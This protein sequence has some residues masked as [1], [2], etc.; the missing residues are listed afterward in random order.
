MIHEKIVPGEI[1]RY[2]VNDL[3]IHKKQTPG[4]QSD[5]T[6]IN[7]RLPQLVPVSLV[8]LFVHDTLEYY[9]PIAIRTITDTV[10]NT[11]KPVYNYTTLYSGTISSLE[12]K[13]F[14]FPTTPINNLEVLISDFDNESLTIDSVEVSGYIY[15]LIGRF[16]GE[17]KYIL[18]YGNG[19]LHT[20][21]YDIEKFSTHLSKELDVATLGSEQNYA[22]TTVEPS[23]SYFSKPWLWA[24][25]AIVILILG[26]FSLKMMNNKD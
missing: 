17:G 10:K 12:D 4:N 23:V 20:P 9:R 1:R 22:E 3:S 13:D 8:K 11:L 25:M 2:S 7:L 26:W 15:Q 16:K 14:F 6:T 24:V 21:K 5:K 18:A 19:D